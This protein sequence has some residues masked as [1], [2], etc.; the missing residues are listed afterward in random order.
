MSDKL[1]PCPFCGGP[2][3][4]LHEGDWWDVTC[5]SEADCRGQTDIPAN[6]MN[7]WVS[8]SLARDGWNQRVGEPRSSGGMSDGELIARAILDASPVTNI[9]GGTSSMITHELARRDRSRGSALL[10]DL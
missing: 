5:D 3:R 9:N 8:E 10:R 4:M 6:G 2:A 7:T 1:K